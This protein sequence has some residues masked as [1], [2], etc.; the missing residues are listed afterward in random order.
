M[1]YGVSERCWRRTTRRQTLRHA[2]QRSWLWMRR[3]SNSADHRATTHPTHVGELIQ[4]QRMTQTTT[5]R[6]EPHS[7]ARPMARG[8]KLSKCRAQWQSLKRANLRMAFRENHTMQKM[9]HVRLTLRLRGHPSERWWQRCEKRPEQQGRDLPTRRETRR[10]TNPPSQQKRHTS[11]Y[12]H[13]P[14]ANSER[15]KSAERARSLSKKRRKRAR[16]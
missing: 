4:H 15:T 8:E 7:A 12:A 16:N 6:L 5:W 14:S 9:R 11:G 2:E 1:A 3:P 10:V 13:T